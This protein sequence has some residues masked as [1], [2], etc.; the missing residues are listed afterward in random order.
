MMNLH[1]DLDMIEVCKMY[2]QRDAGSA[3]R[4]PDAADS[5][6]LFPE[7]TEFSVLLQRAV[8]MAPK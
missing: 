5:S 2:S 7:C 8:Y 1:F 3:E 6:R 4:P